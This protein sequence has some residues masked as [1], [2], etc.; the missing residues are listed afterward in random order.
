[1]RLPEFL[2]LAFCTSV[3]CVSAAD[4]KALPEGT[5]IL[6]MVVQTF[7]RTSIVDSGEQGMLGRLLAEGITDADISDGSVAL[8]IVYCCGG[9][10]TQETAI[11]FYVPPEYR[12]QEGDVVEVSLG[13]IV[14]KKEIKRGDKGTV[15]RAVSVRESF[16]DETG[17]CRWDPPNETLWMRVLYC[18]WMLGEGWKRRGGLS[19]GW[20][21]EPGSRE[22]VTD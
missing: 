19:P 6:A 17:V 10:I 9:K 11:A 18:D 16:K 7:D 5:H 2:L 4:A 22:T 13:R 20:Y 15:N 3:L 12:L 8:G 14:S 21:L 1:M